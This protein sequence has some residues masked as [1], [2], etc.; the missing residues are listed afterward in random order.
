MKNLATLKS[1]SKDYAP[2]KYSPR[3]E[4]QKPV[5]THGDTAKMKE[6]FGVTDKDIPTSGLP[7]NTRIINETCTNTPPNIRLSNNKLIQPIKP[8]FHTDEHHENTS[9]NNT[10][11]SNNANTKN[12]SDT[13][14]NLL[15]L[16]KKSNTLTKETEKP[17]GYPSRATYHSGTSLENSKH[18]APTRSATPDPVRRKPPPVPPLSAKPAYLSSSPNFDRMCNSADELANPALSSS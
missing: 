13:G 1:K 5:E 14:D 4:S 18:P 10:D 12:G 11:F 15:S 6:L 8:A 2:A 9:N 17:K 16:K 7:V 3:S